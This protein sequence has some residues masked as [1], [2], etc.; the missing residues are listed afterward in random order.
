MLCHVEILGAQP[1]LV[2]SL[3]KAPRGTGHPHTQRG[4]TSAAETPGVRGRGRG[5]EK[6]RGGRLPRLAH[7]AELGSTPR[8]LTEFIQQFKETLK[9]LGAAEPLYQTETTRKTK[10]SGHRDSCPPPVGTVTETSDGE[11]CAPRAD[12]LPLLSPLP[13][14]PSSPPRPP[15]HRDVPASHGT[16]REGAAHGVRALPS[17]CL[18]GKIKVRL[19]PAASPL[20]KL[21][22]SSLRV[23][24]KGFPSSVCWDKAPAP[25]SPRVCMFWRL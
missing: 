2:D 15:A 24:G 12:D 8:L 6:G 5:R 13:G 18:P 7:L 17:R 22:P 11:L 20:W 23:R 25:P 3:G 1:G 19:M 14:A 9:A 16:G 10:Q 21:P 4:S